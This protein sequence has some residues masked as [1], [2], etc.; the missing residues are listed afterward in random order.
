MLHSVLSLAA[1]AKAEVD[2]GAIR[3]YVVANQDC[4]ECV[5]EAIGSGG[6]FARAL[7]RVRV[8]L[9]D[10]EVTGAR[11]RPPARPL[12]RPPAR[13]GRCRVPCE[14]LED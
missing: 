5:E 11:P 9:L 14:Y 3:A 10:D 12:A 4:R 7:A 2:G 1:F 13:G 6:A 8:T